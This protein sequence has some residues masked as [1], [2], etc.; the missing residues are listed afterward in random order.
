[1]TPPDGPF[2]KE[3]FFPR[4]L[5]F[6]A[7]A[8]LASLVLP[9]TQS[10]FDTAS[11]FAAWALGILI[12]AA[13]FVVPWQRI[14]RRWQVV[15]PIA[16]FVVVALMRDAAGPESKIGVM[17]LL[18]VVWIA[19]Y[20]SRRET[21]YAIAATTL[22][23]LVPAAIIGPPD[24]PGGE[25]IQSALLWTLFAALVGFTTQNLTEGIRRQSEETAE[26]ARQ[27][28]EINAQFDQ[29]FDGAPL[30]MALVDI[31]GAIMRLNG[32]FCKLL[33]LDPDAMLGQSFEELSLEQDC[34]PIRAAIGRL[35]SGESSTYSAEQR[36]VATSGKEIFGQLNL[37]LVRDGAGD[38]LL[39]F[40]QLQDVTERRQLERERAANERRFKGLL[41]SAPD[42]MVIVDSTGTIVFT[43]TQ[44]S[45][46]FGYTP[47]EMRGQS[48]EMLVPEDKKSQHVAQ[49]N[50]Y[51]SRPRKGPMGGERKVSAR[52]K[53]GSEFPADVRLNPIETDNGLLV[54]S[55]IRDMTAR[56]QV[57]ADLRRL[58]T[59][60]EA[61]DEAILSCSVEG[62]VTAWNKGAEQMFGYSADEI[63]GEYFATLVPPERLGE[64]IE[65][66][67]RVLTGEVVRNHETR[68]M[69]K[70][71][72][73][74]D[75][76]LTVSPIKGVDG[77][78][79]SLSIVTSDVT[80]KNRALA[81]AERLKDEF[82]S[83]VS[84]EFR[85]PLTSIIGY[86]ELLAEFENLGI[87]EDKRAEIIA[88]IKRNSQRLSRLVNDLLLVSKIQG[89]RFALD[90]TSIDVSRLTSESVESA[91]VAAK[92]GGID[93]MLRAKPVPVLEADPDRISQLIDNLVSN[94]VKYT[95]PGGQIRVVLDDTEA[96]IELSVNNTGA[97]IEQAELEQLFEPFFR[98]A[99]ATQNEI[100]GVG[101]G[102]LITKSIV[103]AHNGEIS[104]ESDIADGTTFRVLLPHT[105]T[106]GKSSF[107][108]PPRTQ[109]E[110]A[111]S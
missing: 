40:V 98:A 91:L 42:A 65:V 70:D 20:G 39:L 19:L 82:F 43:N 30:G 38:P 80:E 51:D 13:I 14:D 1:M 85:T 35:K 59:I 27:V 44:A 105:Q 46:L 106:N 81:E 55:S 33:A 53:D 24:Y 4:V 11:Y 6:V 47:G 72:H 62:P 5:P 75:V 8:I 76:M 64:E 16:Y 78:V 21:Y 12:V 74:V 101:L 36:F 45:E 71:G 61:S 83:L 86:L 25:S 92:E 60:V 97:Y 68:A 63:I 66:M 104:V 49:R 79:E 15:P 23:F 2:R 7:G 77:R 17:V 108:Q 52:R 26:R 87:D 99:N 90:K 109:K 100:P 94:A 10:D 88:V 41:E 67:Q 102:L 18:P 103:E 32:F 95:P 34:E 50:G 93:L 31:D 37:T 29:A 57:E 3:G 84:H 69:H 56:R 111:R 96:G 73:R 9:L 110:I 58:A 54:A 22:T 107:A 89:G 28:A 48:V